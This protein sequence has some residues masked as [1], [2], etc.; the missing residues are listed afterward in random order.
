MY[1]FTAFHVLNANFVAGVLFLSIVL[2][3]L[4]P[5]RVLVLKL[6]VLFAFA[7]VMMMMMSFYQL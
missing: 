7:L 4:A 6:V 3:L 5:V 1:L 2:S